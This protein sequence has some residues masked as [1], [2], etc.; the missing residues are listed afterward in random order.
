MPQQQIPDG[1]RPDARR[2]PDIQLS[3]PFVQTSSPDKEGMKGAIS[4][5]QLFSFFTF[6]IMLEKKVFV[7]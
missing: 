6:D 4:P 5:H 7:R 1:A 3:T 2:L